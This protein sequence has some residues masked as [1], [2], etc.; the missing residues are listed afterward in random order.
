MHREWFELTEDR[1]LEVIQTW[2]RWMMR[3]PY[4]RHTGKL[5]PVWSRSLRLM[6]HGDPTK[7][8]GLHR[9][10]QTWTQRDV[11]LDPR[12]V[13]TDFSNHFDIRRYPKRQFS[14]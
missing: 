7:G 2:G 3:Q 8:R 14:F 5:K 11:G 1:A 12:D 13:N 4:H 10:C 9:T 6:K